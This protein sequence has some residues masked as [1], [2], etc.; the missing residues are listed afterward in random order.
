MK[1]ILMAAT[2]A[3]MAG[4]AMAQATT[5]PEAYA[6]G[7][8][9]ELS[10]VSK[11]YEYTVEDARED[12]NFVKNAFRFTLSANVVMTSAEDEDNNAWFAV[13]TYNSSGR[14]IFTSHSDGGSVTSCGDAL[15]QE[16]VKAGELATELG[17]RFDKDGAEPNA[18]LP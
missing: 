13:G 7:E 15:T 5:G 12:R 9:T 6:P 8:T 3:A 11:T 10:T 4:S 14:N 16:E 1:K 18:C 17:T 2:L